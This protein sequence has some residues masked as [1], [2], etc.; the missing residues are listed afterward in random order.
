MRICHSP[1]EHPWV[2]QSFP[3]GKPG[4]HRMQTF[5]P[6]FSCLYWKTSLIS[7][8]VHSSLLAQASARWLDRVEDHFVQK[9][10]EEIVNHLENRMRLS[11]HSMSY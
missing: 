9:R 6:C 8:P 7:S 4:N 3:A 11:Q 1:I 2:D 10:I 5:T